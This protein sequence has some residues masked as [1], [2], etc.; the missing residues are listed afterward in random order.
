MKIWT[1]FPIAFGVIMFF[2]AKD[3]VIP[4]W[5]QLK[6]ESS[7]IERT[8]IKPETKNSYIVD[9]T[10]SNVPYTIYTIDSCEYIGITTSS[11]VLLTHKGN[12]KFCI[13]R[14]H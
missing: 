9:N 1:I 5:N 2:F 7:Y 14:K 6:N 11:G 12:C 3:I 10:G 13:E 8:S 4:K